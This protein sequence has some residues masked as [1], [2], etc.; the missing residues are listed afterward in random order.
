MTS[1]YTTPTGRAVSRMPSTC[2]LLDRHGRPPPPIKSRQFRRCKPSRVA[3]CAW[4]C[5]VKKSDAPSRTSVPK[6]LC[7]KKSV[8]NAMYGSTD[9]THG[10]APHGINYT[11]LQRHM[12]Y[13]I[14]RQDK[15]IAG[16]DGAERPV[17]MR[18]VWSSS[19]WCTEDG[20]ARRRYFNPV[21]G[22]GSW[23][24]R[25]QGLSPRLVHHSGAN[26]RARMMP[27]RPP[28]CMHPLKHP[29]APTPTGKEHR[30][31]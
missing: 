5:T 29:F 2:T 3:H 4:H 6:F 22:N 17:P 18:Y 21:D 25:E 26:H 31:K 12:L 1:P 8:K 27:A 24:Q 19:V 30:V 10:S 11:H 15:I 23:R 20:T 7:W 14:Q 28:W 13:L 16:P 9:T